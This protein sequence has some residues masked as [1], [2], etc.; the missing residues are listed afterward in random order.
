[1][2]CQSKWEAAVICQSKGEASVICKSSVLYKSKWE[3]AVLSHTVIR[4]L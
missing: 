2:P 1:M 4:F 3:A